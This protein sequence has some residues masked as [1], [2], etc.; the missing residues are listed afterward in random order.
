MK[1]LVLSYELQDMLMFCLAYDGVDIALNFT[2][3]SI[4][5]QSRT[6]VQPDRIVALLRWSI[7]PTKMLLIMCDI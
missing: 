6:R 4:R 3:C 7:W 1:S 5:Q 2:T